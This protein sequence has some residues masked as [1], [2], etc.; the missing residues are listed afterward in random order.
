[1]IKKILILLIVAVAIFAAYAAK[2]PSEYRVSRSITINSTAD[3]IF[4]HVNNLKSWN[5]WSPWVKLDPEATV[6]FEG[7]DAGVGAIMRWKGNM[8]VGEGSMTIAESR[9]NEFVKFNLDFV[10]PMKSVANSEFDFKAEGQNTNV[11]W[12]MYGTR[13]FV[14]KAIGVIFNC[15]KMIGEQFDAGL[16]NLKL[17]AEGDAGETVEIQNETPSEP[18]A[19]VES[20][21]SD[22][23]AVAPEVEALPVDEAPA[24]TEN[25][26]ENTAPS[27]DE[28]PANSEVPS[29]TPPVTDTL[30]EQPAAPVNGTQAE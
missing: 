5:E 26:S 28:A 9:N 7:P 30:A 21:P 18:V 23:S 17:T 6:S 25:S 27:A 20:A 19:P 11:T 29:E 13:G 3:K 16:A 1:M 15:E 4:P 22:D 14:E 8:E 24:A 12:T 2:Q 10:K